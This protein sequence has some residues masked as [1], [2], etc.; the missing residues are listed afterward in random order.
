[1]TGA[2]IRGLGCGL[3]LRR[4]ILFLPRIVA[5]FIGKKVGESDGHNEGTEPYPG[6]E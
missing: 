2:M 1:M 3:P 6:S 5:L 4:A